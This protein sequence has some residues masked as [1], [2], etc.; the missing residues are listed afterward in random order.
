MDDAFAAATAP[1][2]GPAFVDFPMDYV[3]MEARR[4]RRSVGARAGVGCRGGG[5]ETAIERAGAL[6]RA[7][8]AR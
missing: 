3:F 7:P 1:H 5:G 6:L 2:G 8:S 4:S